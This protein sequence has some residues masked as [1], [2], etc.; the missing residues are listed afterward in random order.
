MSGDGGALAGEAT[1]EGTMGAARG[2]GRRRC[3]RVVAAL[4]L[5]SG[6]H[7]G[8]ALPRAMTLD[9]TSLQKAT[10]WSRGGISG[11][12]FVPPGEEMDS[13]SVQVGVLLSE[14]H[15]TAEVLS[16]W[17][18]EQYRRSPTMQLFEDAGAETACKVGA[19]SNGSLVRQFLALHSCGARGR[20]SVCAEIDERLLDPSGSPCPP[21]DT[22]C[23]Q[24]LCDA[25]R[26][27]RGPT[28]QSIVDEVLAFE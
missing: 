11:V 25:R 1:K 15:A 24:R 13:A 7:R 2:I 8:P 14:K 9:G 10:S 3:L 6:C 4:F 17:L 21:S 19:T 27:E 28:L 23:W 12:V 20:T 5:L 18:M 22:E 26:V 16:A